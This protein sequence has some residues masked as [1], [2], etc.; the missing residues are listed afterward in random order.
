M[1]MYFAIIKVLSKYDLITQKQI[2]LKAGLMLESPKEWFNFLVDLELIIEKNIENKNVYSITDKGQKL[3]EYF[4]LD[5]DGS[6]FYGSKINRI[7]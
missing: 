1:E 4:K 2:L 3:C 6:I 5:D 7:D